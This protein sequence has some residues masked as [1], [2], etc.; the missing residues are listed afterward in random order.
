MGELK[1]HAPI[2]ALVHRNFIALLAQFQGDFFTGRLHHFGYE[3]GHMGPPRHHGDI[4][5]SPLPPAVG[6][7]R[8][9]GAGQSLVAQPAACGIEAECPEQAPDRDQQN[10]GEGQG[11]GN[12]RGLQRLEAVGQQQR[13]GDRAYADRPEDALPQRRMA[14]PGRGQHIDHKRAGVRR[15]DEEHHHHEHRYQRNDTG[16]REV[17]EKGEQGQGTVLIDHRGQVLDTLVEDHVY[18]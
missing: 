11:T 4:A 14:L 18:R 3:A 9:P 16:E 6:M 10:G 2:F 1:H 12:G 5:Q 17:L 8:M 15:G 7:A 13:N